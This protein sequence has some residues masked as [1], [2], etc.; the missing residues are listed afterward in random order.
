MI[1]AFKSGIAITPQSVTNAGT[2]AGK[3]IDTKG[4]DYC[5]LTIHMATTN[6]TSNVPT[7]ITIKEGDTTSAMATFTGCVQ[8]TD[9][10][11]ATTA[12][13]STAGDNAYSFA[14]DLRARKRYLQI[15]AVSPVTTQIT[16]GGYVLGKGE[17]SPLTAAQAGV[18]NAVY[19]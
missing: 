7:V 15:S 14:V 2:A 9:Y 17:L 1:P 19:V 16:S 4:W 18:L 5:L 3:I 10:T 6:D 11:V 13:T 8:N 12:Y